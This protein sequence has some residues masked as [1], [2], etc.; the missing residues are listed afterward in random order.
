MVFLIQVSNT[1][2]LNQYGKQPGTSRFFKVFEQIINAHKK[3]HQ[4]LE[5]TEFLKRLNAVVL[6]RYNLL[7]QIV[8]GKS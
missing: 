7:V 3:V 8:G 4:T 6:I 5:N 2:T 1:T